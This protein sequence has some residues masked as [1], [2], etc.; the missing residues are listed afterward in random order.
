MFALPRY[1]LQG[2]ETQFTT[3]LPE[4]QPVEIAR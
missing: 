2:R 4:S 3:I 1:E